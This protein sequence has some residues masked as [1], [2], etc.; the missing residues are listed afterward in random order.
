MELRES[1]IATKCSV[2]KFRRR[3]FHVHS[4]LVDSHSIFIR[5]F[6]NLISVFVFILP[7]ALNFEDVTREACHYYYRVVLFLLSC[8]RIDWNTATNRP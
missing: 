4:S 3:S 6:K 2:L 5:V 7:H 8:V 1:T